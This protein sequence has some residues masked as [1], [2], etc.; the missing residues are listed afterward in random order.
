MLTYIV[1]LCAYTLYPPLY[2]GESSMPDLPTTFTSNKGDH[3]EF[4]Q[5]GSIV[6]KL[7]TP[8]VYGDSAR[9]SMGITY[10]VTIFRSRLQVYTFPYDTCEAESLLDASLSLRYATKADFSVTP[11]A[12]PK[13]ST[14][15]FADVPTVYATWYDDVATPRPAFLT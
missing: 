15:L 9:T 14:A 11:G 13:I 12:L 5:N 8:V 2:E 7:Y 3:R 6:Y 10:P 1:L 4:R